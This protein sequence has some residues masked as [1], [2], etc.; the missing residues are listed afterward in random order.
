MTV[1]L[2]ELIAEQNNTWQRMQEIRTAADAQEGGW[3]AEQRQTWD[4]AETRMTELEG[5]I[6]RE[7]RFEQLNGVDRSQIVVTNTGEE[8]A[9]TDAERRYA[10]VFG[11]YMKRGAGRLTDEQRQLL[12][13][14]FVENRDQG[15]GTDAAGGYLVPEGFRN[16]MIET[17]KAYGGIEELAQPITTDTGQNLPWVTND[18]TANEG[19]IIGENTAV[20]QQ[21]LTFGGRSLKA[22]NFSSKM[23]VIPLPLAQDSAFDLETFIPRKAGERIGRRSAR[24]WIA[25]TGVDEPEGI[26]TH[27]TAGK[28]GANGQTVSV[29]YDDFIDLEHSVD[30]AYR[31]DRCGFVMHDLTLATV[32]KLKDGQQRPLWVPIPAPG[33]TATINGRRYK[34]DNNMP[35]MAANAKSILFGDIYAAYV[36]RTVRGISQIRLAERYAE[37]LQ[38]AYFSWA[39]KDG[40]VQDPNAVKAYVNSAT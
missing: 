23:I 14:H 33:F 11:I 5:D 37:K 22:F 26:T 25:G 17:M 9:A 13:G 30:V 40:M 20:T 6:A 24:A 28:T 39:R 3:T 36:V 35:Q 31:N 18:D 10:E 12:E 8:R 4:T 7:Q 19:E 21:D 16:E 29:I 38:V 2:R 34:I 32:R 15:T 27:V 1:Q